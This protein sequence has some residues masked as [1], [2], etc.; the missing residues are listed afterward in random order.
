MKNLIE[1]LRKEMV[2]GNRANL[3]YDYCMGL[4]FML[5]IY[6]LIELIK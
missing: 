3:F 5:I 6:C 1:F 4:S 2:K